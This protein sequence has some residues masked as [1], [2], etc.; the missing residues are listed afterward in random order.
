MTKE[1]GLRTRFGG[2]L[3][4]KDTEIRSAVFRNEKKSGSS[5][6]SSILDKTKDW[7]FGTNLVEAK[8]HLARLHKPGAS[9]AER[10]KSFLALRNL[11]GEGFRDRFVVKPEP[12]G[13]SLI[14]DYGNYQ[15]PYCHS[16]TICSERYLQ[17]TSNKLVGDALSE[18][19][20]KKVNKNGL[21]KHEEQLA[22]D[23]PRSDYFMDGKLIEGVKIPEG[24][25]TNKHQELLDVFR[26][27]LEA[28]APLPEK[29]RIA[30]EAL[31]SQGLFADIVSSA[32][33]HNG[34]IYSVEEGGNVMQ[35]N[36]GELKY[37]LS[38]SGNS[39]VLRAIRRTDWL[40]YDGAPELSPMLLTP[41]FSISLAIAPDGHA[42]VL[43]A[44]Y[45][46]EPYEG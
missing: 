45:G 38:R 31:A 19:A 32:L 24:N 34:G 16:L 11:V 39:I 35:G 4:I 26:S 23:L 22:N 8:E 7:F 43:S 46:S 33:T 30:V 21:L 20:S 36:G 12:F 17:E 18:A 14:I 44:N 5:S 1:I 10:V 37:L 9:D 15:L 13:Y 3:Y 42:T 6:L 41:A 27:S 40:S 28:D 25:T 29:Q 2:N